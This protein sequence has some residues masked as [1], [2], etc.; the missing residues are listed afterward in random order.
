LFLILTKL[1]D[2]DGQPLQEAEGDEQAAH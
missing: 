1:E 2:T